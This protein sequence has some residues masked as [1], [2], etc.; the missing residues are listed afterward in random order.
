MS[1]KEQIKKF[2]KEN[3]KELAIAGISAL[4]GG[5]VVYKVTKL[6]TE[7]KML[8]K[9]LKKYGYHSEDGNKIFKDLMLA[10]EGSKRVCILSSDSGV[11][12]EELGKATIDV[13]KEKDWNLSRHAVGMVL[14][15]DK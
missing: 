10:M 7:E 9:L 13:F 6:S 5:F 11:S 12:I 14:F 1:K 4:V 8:C 3:K 2:V 15:T